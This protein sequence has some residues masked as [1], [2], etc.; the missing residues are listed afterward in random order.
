MIALPVIITAVRVIIVIT[1]LVSTKPLRLH[2][3]SPLAL[4][5]R[6]EITMRAH[7]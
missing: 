4:G 1:W 6:G 2:D 3:T 7:R 5:D